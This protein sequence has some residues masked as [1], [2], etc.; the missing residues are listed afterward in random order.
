MDYDVNQTKKA[1]RIIDAKRGF[2]DK[3][4]SYSSIRLSTR[5]E[6]TSIV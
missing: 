1:V 5:D 6:V 3:V 2:T 4:Y